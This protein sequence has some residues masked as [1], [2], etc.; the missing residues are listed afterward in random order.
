MNSF[1][2]EIY[3]NIP[4]Y[5][6]SQDSI[7]NFCI[8]KININKVMEKNIEEYDL[9]YKVNGMIFRYYPSSILTLI[10]DLDLEMNL[11]KERSN[12]I[13]T[14]SGYPVLEIDFD[15]ESV[16]FIDPIRDGVG[17][18]RILGDRFWVFAV[19]DVIESALNR[20]KKYVMYLESL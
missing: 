3:P 4:D 6:F 11:F 12:H 10:N 15:G 2:V 17:E 20:V 5:F 7:D 16:L 14:L 9:I 18:R 13:V 19:E 1:S 8:D